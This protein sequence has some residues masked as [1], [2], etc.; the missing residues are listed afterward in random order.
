MKSLFWVSA[1]VV[2]YVYFGY[3]A[4]LF[5]RAR[6][7]PKPVRRAAFTPSVSIVLVV[8]NEEK[9]LERKL[10]DLLRLDYPREQM[11]WV[12]VSDGSRDGTNEILRR[13]AG[14]GPGQIILRPEAGGKAAG[15]NQ[16]IAAA[17][18][19]IVLFTDAR[20][21]IEPQA[22]RCLMENFADPDVGC[23]S[24]ELML[25]NPASGEAGKGM[26][27]YWRVEKMIRQLESASGSVIGATGAIYAVRREFLVSLPAETILDD[28][29][30][31]MHVIQKGARVVFEAGARAWDLPDQ[32]REQ[33]FARKVRTL[34]GNYQLLEL[35]PW[36]LRKTNPV[37]FELVSHKLLR[38]LVPF[39][40]AASLLT[41]ALI[42]G[43]VYRIFFALQVL[44]YGS[45]LLALGGI[46][47]GPLARMADVALTFVALNTAA[48]VALAN[49]LSGRK[50]VWLR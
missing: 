41:S 17:R 45:S 4:W 26:G 15:L 34:S 27:L 33:E 50:V 35:A 29:Y 5:L 19:E 7:R 2:A 18:G 8:R 14:T 39:A 42:P 12:V 44:F 9:V 49:F 46:K 10:Q 37:R 47:R 11:E 36:L 1:A 38:L 31:P 28:V 24:G 48:V 32:G 22:L 25:G 20:Q 23:V 43:P 40:L 6:C 21:E 30:I 16:A 3:A 13:H